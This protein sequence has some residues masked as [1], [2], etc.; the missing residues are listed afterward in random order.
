M[1]KPAAKATAQLR[2]MQKPDLPPAP[3]T[4]KPA[5]AIIPGHDVNVNP[6]EHNAARWNPATKSPPDLPDANFGR[7]FER[8]SQTIRFRARSDG[9]WPSAG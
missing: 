3:R 9:P 7:E 4:P 1:P 5:R 6:A 2:P 8:C